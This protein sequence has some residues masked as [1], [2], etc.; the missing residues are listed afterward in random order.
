MVSLKKW[1]FIVIL[2][3]TCVI[4]WFESRDLRRIYEKNCRELQLTLYSHQRHF[5]ELSNYRIAQLAA[6]V[7]L[8]ICREAYQKTHRVYCKV[9]WFCVYRVPYSF[10]KMSQPTNTSIGCCLRWM[11][12]TKLHWYEE[13]DLWKRIPSV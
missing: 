12:P 3:T 11:C 5:Q 4:C 1:C 13:R 9:S 10:I 6:N 2:S 8:E 7:N